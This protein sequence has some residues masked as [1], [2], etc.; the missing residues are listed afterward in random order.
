M[1]DE[2]IFL[3]NN[4]SGVFIVFRLRIYCGKNKKIPVHGGQSEGNNNYY[5]CTGFCY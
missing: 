5:L 2:F 4:L 1:A 3:Y